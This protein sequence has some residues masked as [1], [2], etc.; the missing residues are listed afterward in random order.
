MIPTRHKCVLAADREKLLQ[1]ILCFL[2][3]PQSTQFQA[4]DG[5][6]T[7]QITEIKIHGLF[8]FRML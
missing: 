2:W 3:E 8:N 7:I 5:W 4:K 1:R 6:Q